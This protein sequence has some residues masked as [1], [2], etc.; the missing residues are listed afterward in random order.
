MYCVALVITNYIYSALCSERG[1]IPFFIVIMMVMFAEIIYSGE[2]IV[3]FVT[4]L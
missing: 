4:Q 3:H 2:L 1:E